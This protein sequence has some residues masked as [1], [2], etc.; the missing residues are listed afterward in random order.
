[1]NLHF[2][3][4]K[5]RI[6]FET[7]HWMCIITEFSLQTMPNAHIASQSLTITTQLVKPLCGQ[8]WP[9]HRLGSPALDDKIALICVVNQT[10]TNWSFFKSFKKYPRTLFSNLYSWFCCCFWKICTSINERRWRGNK[11]NIL[12]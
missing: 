8:W 5:A 12:L 6:F 2:T 4:Q 1:M 7:Q 3:N 11:A 10:L 9:S